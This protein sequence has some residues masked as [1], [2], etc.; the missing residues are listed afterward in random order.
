L[1]GVVGGDTV[2]LAGTPV[3][4]FVDADAG[5]GKT[6]NVSGYTID[7]A[8]YS[9][10]Q[11]TLAANIT[12]K[13]ITVT[14][15]AG[16]SKVYGTADPAFTYTSSDLTATFTG[17]LSRVAGENVGTYAITGHSVGRRQPHRYLC[18]GELCHHGGKYDDL[19]CA[20]ANPSVGSSVTFTAT[21]SPL[22]QQVSCSSTPMA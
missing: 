22:P 14:A 12:P 21:V 7:N 20:S 15:D 16:Q 2:N 11:P 6:V 10:T 13:P 18:L 1:A 3:A 4:T 19:A 5:T 9:L 17:A 8:N